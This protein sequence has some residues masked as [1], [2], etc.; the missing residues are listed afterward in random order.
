MY[1]Y[2]EIYKTMV[3]EV[4]NLEAQGYKVESTP[5]SVVFC[6]GMTPQLLLS[7]RRE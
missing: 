3:R 7:P 4:K 1:T 2:D 6:C 5:D